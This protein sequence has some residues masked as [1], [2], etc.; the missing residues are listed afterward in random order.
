MIRR[1]RP[2]VFTGKVSLADVPGSPFRDH[3]DSLAPSAREKALAELSRLLVP[4]ADVA[5]L[6]SDD[7]GRLYYVCNL[8]PPADPL[9]GA[10]SDDAAPSQDGMHHAATAAEFAVSV[11]NSAPPFRHSRPGS[12]NVIYLDFTGH[13]VT[14]TAWNTSAGAAAAYVCIPYDTDGNASSFSPAEQATIVNLWARVAEDFR[15]FDVNVTTEEPSAAAFATNRVARVVITRPTDANGVPNP[16]SATASGVAYLN[17]FGTQSYASTYNVSFVYHSA[18]TDGFVASVISH[19]VGH[20]LGLSHDGTLNIDGTKK[21]EYYA[22]HGTGP[23]SWSPIMGSGSTQILQ[24]SRGEYHLANNLQDDLAI[25]SALLGLRPDDHGNTLATATALIAN[26]DRIQHRGVIANAADTDWFS[27]STAG[28]ASLT[29]A[30]QTSPFATN[31]GPL[32]VR[33]ELYDAGGNLIANADPADST[34]VSLSPSLAAG[35]YFLRVSGANFGS[36]LANPPNGYTAY[37][38]IGEYTITGTATPLAGTIAAAIVQ[39]PTNQ[40]EFPGNRAVFTVIARGQPATNYQ[41]QR[42]VDGNTWHPLSN[43][44]LFAG[45]TTSM[46]TIAAV[47]SAQNGHRFRCVVTNSTGNVTSTAAT[48][49]V[50]TP[51]PPVLPAFAGA[52][53]PTFGRGLPSGTSQN[54]N[55]ALLAGSDPITLQWRLNGQPIPGANGAYYF[56]RNWQ[57]ADAGVYTVVA[58]NP[59]GSVESPPYTQY[60]QPEGGWNWRNP[61]PTGNGLTRAAF[62]NGQF[63]VGGLRGTMLVSTD[64]FNWTTRTLPASNNLYGFHYFNGLYVVLGSLGAVFSSPD[65]IHWTPRDTGTLHQDSSSGLQFV[66]NSGSRLMAV[67]LGGIFTTSTDGINWTAGTIGTADDLN[68]VAF[69]FGRF[70]AVSNTNG[71]VYSSTDGST[72]TSVAS[73]TSAL[74]CITFGAGRLV[75]AGAGGAIS[76]STDGIAWSAVASGTSSSIIGLDFVN[77]QFIATGVSGTILTSPDGTQWTLRSS[78]GNLSQL[79]NTAYGYGVYVIPGQSGT[80]GRALLVSTNGITWSERI[81]GAGTLGSHLRTAASNGITLV[82]G[83][84]NGALLYS[85]DGHSWSNGPSYGSTLNDVTFANGLYVAV[86][87]NTTALTSTDGTVWNRPSPNLSGVT[88]NGVHHGAGTWIA[89]GTAGGAARIYTAS[90]IGSWSQ[91]FSGTGALNKITSGNGRFVAVGNDGSI[92][93]STSPASSAWSAAN[94]GTTANLLDVTHGHGLFAA[95]GA[96]VVLTSPDGLTW[97]NRSFTPDSL[98]SVHFANGWFLATGPGSTYYVSPDGVNW[99]GRFTGAA[100]AVNDFVAFNNQIYGVGDNS[101]ILA[102]G[103][104]TLR[105]PTTLTAV[106]GSSATLAA[107]ASGSPVTVTYQWHRNGAPV[108]GA[109]SPISTLANVSTA[110]AGTYTLVATNSFGTTTSAAVTLNVSPATQSIT[111]A[112]IADLLFRH[113][114]LLLNASASSG[115]PV[116]FSL[117]D[118]PATLNGNSLTL[119]GP[120][121]V[122]VRATQPGNADFSAAPPVERTFLVLPSF[123]SW[124]RDNFTGAELANTSISGPLAIASSDGLSNA[125]KYALGLLAKTPANTTLAISATATEWVVTFARPTSVIDAFYTVELSTDLATWTSAGIIQESVSIT[126]GQETLRARAPLSAT[127]AF[128][129]LK[130]TL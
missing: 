48:L 79:Q 3:L 30:P 38:T 96:G 109:T 55:I 1:P 33:V 94:S 49:T 73:S 66:A 129:R 26:G 62:L 16:S 82:A 91:R 20:N 25:M 24:W 99:T 31:K 29:I 5:S 123:A 107:T 128:F 17:V 8:A 61:T 93:T 108:A 98:T 120:G 119:T 35:T 70:H 118:G 83:G 50:Q 67:G 122:T 9:I 92:V 117:L 51:P 18:Y 10:A 64:G 58:S 102:A 23:T 22:G 12:A 85:V 44:A 57:P 46:L 42:S 121:S 84:L 72:W 103:A 101:T 89:V 43:D 47:D 111:F 11:P 71:R 13:T 86:G 74:R 52:P 80:T 53:A 34:S 19:E 60:L 127:P 65:A 77:G 116:S 21:D 90:S 39:H 2:A 81:A 76:T 78:G 63:F 36:P 112:P 6:R 69:G 37:A 68:G 97:T 126:N 95:V 114:P 32:D 87:A 115:L 105:T 130:I 15:A 106:S 125:V 104:P 100:D 124:Q 7:S 41:W 110:H 113:G 88:F 14:G 4:L 27:F 28:T 75:A 56:V 40:S 59:L 45:A 54:L